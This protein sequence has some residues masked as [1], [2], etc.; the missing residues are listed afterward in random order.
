M[1]L[2][3][4]FLWHRIRN[5]ANSLVSAF[6]RTFRLVEGR[7]SRSLVLFVIQ[8][9]RL[10]HRISKH[11]GYKGLSLLLKAAHQ[12]TMKAASGN[13][14]E[15][16]SN[17]RIALTGSGIPRL[18]PPYV[19][20]QILNRDPIWVKRCLTVLGLYRVLDFK[21]KWNLKT[22][23]DPWI[24]KEPS[25]LATFIPIFYDYLGKPSLVKGS[26]WETL[27]IT[28]SGPGR[29]SLKE[30]RTSSSLGNALVNLW[31]LHSND[32][33]WH[34]YVQICKIF[35]FQHITTLREVLSTIAG[36]G[37]L[38][39]EFA[40]I[41]PIGKLG[42]KE[43]PGKKRIF[44]MVDYWTQC[45]LYPLH[46]SIFKIL[47]RIKEDAT[48]DQGRGVGH[49]LDLIRSGHNHVFSFDLSAATDRLPIGFQRKLLNMFH[50]ELGDHWSNLLVNR[51]YSV[52]CTSHAPKGVVRYA[53]GQPMGA[54]SSWAML[55]L[56]HHLL[57]QFAAYKA[58]WRTW[59]NLYMVLGDDII[60]LD[61]SVASEYLR[62][63][64]ELGVGIS[65][66]KS[67]ISREGAGEF[68][69]RFFIKNGIDVSPISLSEA[70]VASGNL[71]AILE[72]CSRH[73]TQVSA[74]SLRYFQGKG[75]RVGSTLM[76][77]FSKQSHSLAL[78][79]RFF[80]I[81]GHSNFSFP[82]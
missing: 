81:P 49:V 43:E 23:T 22:I 66:F 12:A 67:V 14:L 48:F 11:S 36:D 30:S 51:D 78:L 76:A 59:F 44:A 52:K 69:K 37:F 46:L 50:S 62:V 29:L 39:S 77:P 45:L 64:R 6:L 15:Q 3:S 82:N 75:F 57:V 1:N 68:A 18:L 63:L 19:R 17:P 40:Q 72:L 41:R 80:S 9:L 65:M 25:G 26:T 10:Y 2:R 79:L 4:A 73:R 38:R 8:Q 13:P 7:T 56:S 61:G 5:N 42:I 16:T 28:K 53:T 58:G 31:S 55:A 71:S 21:G 24:G 35:S 60:I 74:S 34:S 47:S 33:L 32:E 20:T 54:Y 27:L 70:A